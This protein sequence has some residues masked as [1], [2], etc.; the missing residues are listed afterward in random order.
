MANKIS[1]SLNG[2]A[3]EKYIE[4]NLLLVDF[5]RNELGLTGTK[6]GCGIGECGACTVLINGEP[7]N[8]C[9]TLAVTIDGKEIITVEGLAADKLSPLQEAF[10]KEG[11]VQCGYCT[12]GM[13]LSTKALLD[14]NPD[15]DENQIKEAISGNLCRCTGY[16]AIVR[17]VQRAA[18][19]L[20]EKVAE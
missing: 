19:E 18:K 11:A 20:K 9:L 4:P 6:V 10:I 14:K 3:M 13:L 16:A 12:P 1:F 17:A 15:P 2:V 7:V 8:S 5:L